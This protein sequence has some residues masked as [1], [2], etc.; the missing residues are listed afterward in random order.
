VLFGYCSDMTSNQEQSTNAMERLAAAKLFQATLDILTGSGA[1]AASAIVWVRQ[2]GEDRLSFESCCRLL[3]R[4]F[5]VWFERA[6]PQ[7][8]A[9]GLLGRG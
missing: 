1:T 9:A 2:C 5:P 7:A 3:N 8:R 4:D 6:A